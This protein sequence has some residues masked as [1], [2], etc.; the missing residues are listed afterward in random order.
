MIELFFIAC[1][2][3]SPDVCEERRLT[4]A[5]PLTPMACMMGAQ[6][7][8]AQWAERHPKWR[9]DRWACRKAGFAGTPA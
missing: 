8:L 3:Q 7:Q 9:I 2:A 4:F 1:L 5:E 6:P